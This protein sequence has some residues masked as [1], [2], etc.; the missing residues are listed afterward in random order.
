ME[1][2]RAV[3]LT[4]TR[5]GQP[6]RGSGLR[7]G[8]TI[9]L[10][11]NHCTHGTDHKAFADGHR[12]TATVV[13]RSGSTDVDIA[14][15]DAPD[16]TP[17]DP[18]QF[19]ALPD[20]HAA[21]VPARGLGFP[22]WNDLGD[23]RRRT[24]TVGYVPTGE[25]PD[26]LTTGT[27]WLAAYRIPD[28][29]VGAPPIQ[30]GD[31]DETR[32]AGFSGTVLVTRTG[33]QVLGV[34][35]GH[36]PDAGVGTLVFTPIQAVATLDPDT[37][38]EFC[39]RLSISTPPAWAAVTDTATPVT[40]KSVGR[41]PVA[42]PGFVDRP[43]TTEL[44]NTLTSTRVSVLSALL[45]M[46]GVGK[47]QLAGAV[48]RYCIDQ[49]WPLVGWVDAATEQTTI[50][51]LAAIAAELDVSDPDGDP[52]RS[53][54]RLR[55][56][57]TTRPGT[58]L[59]VFDNGTNPDHLRTYLPAS[60]TCRVLIT[61]THT[62]FEHLGTVVELD[63]YSRQQSID[64]LTERTRLDDP[65]GADALADDLG[66]LPLA[67]A[68]AAAVITRRQYSYTTYRKHLA[69]Y[70]LDQSL[71][72]IQGHDYPHST[73][74]ALSLTLDTLDAPAH[75]LAT[76]IALL[77]PDGV[78]HRILHHLTHSTDDADPVF[79][80]LELDDA[81]DDLVGLS[82]LTRSTD[83]TLTLH[84]LTARIIRERAT[85]AQ[86]TDAGTHA[87]HALEQSRIPDTD[88]WVHRTLGARLTTHV[89]TLWHHLD[90]T[91]NTPLIVRLL[92]LRD[93]ALNNRT[94]S[95]DLT[96][97]I[98][99]GTTLVTDRDRILGTDHPDTLIT[100][101]NLAGAY[102]SAGRL[103]DAITLYEHTLTDSVHILGPDHP[104]TLTFRNN[105]AYAYHQAG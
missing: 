105:L 11:A 15:L 3:Y 85:P 12:S 90:T 53:A 19:A 82:L 72:R 50:T 2:S 101:N 104:H 91:T 47:S 26:A 31:Q 17:V 71:R 42:P 84:R 20:T 10:T 44:I 45:G 83:N 21:E 32:W 57:L 69:D 100:R 41:I 43:E 23:Q 96:W 24:Q 35:R 88:T 9:I 7:I 8:G 94:D 6:L 97:A 39:H 63:A 25:G 49:R 93:W 87:A 56:H 62:A 59:L 67:L 61:T 14:L 68:A 58:S 52:Q 74:E 36:M 16:L 60:G 79:T 13:W 54:K 95:A 66:D 28:P 77:A 64:Y 55:D 33:D 73:A 75:R 27:M 30:A 99:L 102:D 51:D 29:P 5:N 92:S 22:K 98:T 46:R 76:I 103:D 40:R 70:P 34:V 65:D 78:E 18:L 38:T 48:A 4:Y 89:D 80:D 81:L 86:L 37:A 1:P